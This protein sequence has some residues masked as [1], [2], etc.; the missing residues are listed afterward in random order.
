MP[1]WGARVGAGTGAAGAGTRRSSPGP[2][3]RPLRPARSLLE[4]VG[5]VVERRPGDIAE[6]CAAV[7][8]IG[9]E[10]G[11]HARRDVTAMVRDLWAWQEANPAGFSSR[12]E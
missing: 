7:D 6:S 11:W 12:T 4:E 8:A 9:A 2:P 3:P 5:Q 10:V 1:R